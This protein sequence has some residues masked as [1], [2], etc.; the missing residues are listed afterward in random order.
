MIPQ[1]SINMTCG[2]FVPRGAGLASIVPMRAGHISTTPLGS[3][4]TLIRHLRARN[5]PRLPL[6]ALILSPPEKYCL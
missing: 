6:G 3:G 1:T 2:L 4:I 5:Y